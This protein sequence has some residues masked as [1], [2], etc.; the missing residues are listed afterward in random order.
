M[1][2]EIHETALAREQIMLDRL[3]AVLKEF[4][5]NPLNKE[6]FAAWKQNKEAKNETNHYHGRLDTGKY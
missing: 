4:Y 1:R 5:D 3:S 2:R 6:A